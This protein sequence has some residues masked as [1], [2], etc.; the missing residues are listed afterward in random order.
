ML[1]L[2]LLQLYWDGRL[3]ANFGVDEVLDIL[4]GPSLENGD[5]STL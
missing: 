2:V 3:S 1:G 5:I 4:F